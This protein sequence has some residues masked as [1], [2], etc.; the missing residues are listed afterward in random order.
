MSVFCFY[1]LLRKRSG[2]RAGRPEAFAASVGRKETWVICI[3]PLL[4]AEKF[5][6]GDGNMFALSRLPLRH[7]LLRA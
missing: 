7:D 3:A 6:H 5:A 1:L 2:A 4:Y